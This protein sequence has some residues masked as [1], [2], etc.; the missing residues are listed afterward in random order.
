MPARSVQIRILGSDLPGRG[1][2]ASADFPGYE[3]IHV[4]VQRR[5]R[6]SELLGVVPGDVSSAEW[7][8]ACEVAE[9]AT[10]IDWKGPYIQGRPHERFIY[11]SW[12]TVDGDGTFTMFRRAKLWLDCID[13][14]TVAAAFRSGTLVARLGLTDAKGNPLCAAVRPPRVEWSAR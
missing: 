12:G 11:L 13:P 5:Q 7:H 2:A 3:N 4:G 9:A 6:P 1:C 10:G 8:L 14:E